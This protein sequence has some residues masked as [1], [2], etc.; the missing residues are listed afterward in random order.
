VGALTLVT[1]LWLAAPAKAPPLTPLEAPLGSI[2]GVVEPFEGGG[3]PVL[4]VGWAFT[5]APSCPSQVLWLTR[6]VGGSLRALEQLQAWL[7]SNPGVEATLF[8]HVK[9]ATYEPLVG[10]GPRPLKAGWQLAFSTAPKGYELRRDA[11]QPEFWFFNGERRAAAAVTV[12]PGV[13]DVCRP[14]LSVVL[15]D[16]SGAARLRLHADWAKEVSASLV[17]NGCKAVHFT[18]D[19]QGQRFTPSLETRCRK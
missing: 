6:L 8:A 10:A 12:A 1:A 18:F 9:A 17:G 3:A 5:L 13:G 7:E 4:P 16:A 14:R 2:G 15:F 11:D 19:A